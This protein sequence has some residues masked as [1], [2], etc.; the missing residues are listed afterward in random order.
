MLQCAH[1]ALLIQLAQRHAADLRAS[2]ALARVHLG[3]GHHTVGAIEQ[4]LRAAEEAE[5]DLAREPARQV[6]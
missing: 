4:R 1:K 3:K 6:A 5:R 2:L